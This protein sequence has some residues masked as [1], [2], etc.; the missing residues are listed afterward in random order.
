MRLGGG[1]DAELAVSLCRDA[2]HSTIVRPRIVGERLR[3]EVWTTR[4]GVDSARFAPAT[5][6][7]WTSSR[8]WQE[9]RAA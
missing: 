4:A 7:I 5:G 6:A 2:V 9:Q 8:P 1:E 3:S